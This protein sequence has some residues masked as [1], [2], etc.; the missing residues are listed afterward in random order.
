M[1]WPNVR[2]HL[3]PGRARDEWGP[4]QPL[5]CGDES[6]SIQAS[7]YHYCEPR[8]ERGPWTLVEVGGRHEDALARWSETPSDPSDS[9]F[10]Y[11]PIDVVQAIV[12][13]HEAIGRLYAGD[14]DAIV[15]S[16]ALREIGRVQT[17]GHALTWTIREKMT[18]GRALRIMVCLRAW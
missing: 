7:R 4:L 18:F 14:K 5:H 8:N 3:R 9:V 10:A 12:D 11:V 17:P 15:M 6:L 1:T 13:M 2:D 16:D